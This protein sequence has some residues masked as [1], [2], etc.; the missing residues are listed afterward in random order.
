ML[1][2]STTGPLIE[3]LVVQESNGVD[4]NM[5]DICLA[6]T[7]AAT[8]LTG[9]ATPLARVQYNLLL[10]NWV[11]RTHPVLLGRLVC[12]LRCRLLA[13][14]QWH[15]LLRSSLHPLLRL[16]CLLCQVRPNQ[17][18]YLTGAPSGFY[19]QSTRFPYMS[20]SS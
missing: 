20:N 2:T 8:P 15:P 5:A 1:V 10:C 16:S 3:D 17:M 11:F 19:S 13:Y 6:I 9:A 12:P 4:S 18:G 7:V 14:R